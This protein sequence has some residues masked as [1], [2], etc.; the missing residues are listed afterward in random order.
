MTALVLLV[1]PPGAGK[2]TWARKYFPRR[3]QRVRLDEYRW[4]ACGDEADQTATPAACAIMHTVVAERMRRRL[5]T[6]VDATNAEAEHRHQLVRHAI[7]MRLPTVAVVLHV[8]VAVCI[9]RQAGRRRP[10]ATCPNGRMVPEAAIRDAHARIRADLP[11]LRSGGIWVVAHFAW[12]G[13][14]WRQ[15]HV[16]RTDP[17]LRTALPWLAD[18]REDVRRFEP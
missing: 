11:T 4:M 2:T 14:A 13:E 6:V 16:S 10:T 1:A 12:G 5:L 3:D 15:G 7:G 8:P 17:E 18:L 9:A